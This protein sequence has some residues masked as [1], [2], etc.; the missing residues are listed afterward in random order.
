MPAA[1]APLSSPAFEGLDAPVHVGSRGSHLGCHV[2][3]REAVGLEA[4]HR[5]AEG[6]ALAHVRQ[7]Q[8]E[9]VLGRRDRRHRNREPLAGQMLHQVAEALALHA[10]AVLRRYLDLV[11]IQL[12]GVLRA[13]PDLVELAAAVEAL[14]AILDYEQAETLPPS[15]SDVRA[16]TI[17]RSACRPLVTNVFDPLSR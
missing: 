7:G 10:Q 3:H 2:G 15:P 8:L 11:E 4:P 17:T 1:S 6:V 12:G 16:A 9:S 13:A 5:L 14:G